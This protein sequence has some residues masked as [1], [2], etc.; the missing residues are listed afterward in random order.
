MALTADLRSDTVTRPSPAM[1][2]AMASAD[3]A[4]DVLEGDPTTRRLEEVIADMLGKEAALFVPSGTMAN[5][6]AVRLHCGR[7]EEFICES[8][9]HIYVY[10]QAGY[11]QLSG[12]AAQALPGVEGVLST[13]QVAAAIRPDDDHFPRTAMLAVENTANKAG[14]IVQ[15]QATVE[16]LCELA[17]SRGM[18]THMDGARFFNA[19]VATGLAPDQLASPFDTVSVCFSK[20]LGAPVGSALCGS[21]RLVSKAQRA[22]K[23]YGGGMRQSGFLAA[24]GL[25]ALENNIHHLSQDHQHAHQL[26]AAIGSCAKLRLLAEPQSNIVIFRVDDSLGTAE[27]FE[28]QLATRGV[29]SLAIGPTTIRLVTHLDVSPEQISY[30]CTEITDIAK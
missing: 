17:R 8:T 12:V 11:A 29:L 4:D 1:L 19:A 7:D 10:E 3:V 2:E 15:P 26:A 5:Q 21:S 14:G 13:E 27:K 20:G 25:Y 6:I 23:L 9:C 18:T 30:A 28:Q 16:A 24:A 22:R